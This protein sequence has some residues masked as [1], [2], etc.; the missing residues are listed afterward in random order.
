VPRTYF[1]AESIQTL[2]DQRQGEIRA[3]RNKQPGDEYRPE[4]SAMCNQKRDN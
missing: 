4:E 3:V 1:R 2:A